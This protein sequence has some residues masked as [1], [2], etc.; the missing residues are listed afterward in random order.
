M[1]NELKKLM[2]KIEKFENKCLNDI[3]KA[4]SVAVYKCIIKVSKL[5]P[6]RVISFRCGNGATFIEISGM[7]KHS[8]IILEDYLDSYCDWSASDLIR[9]KSHPLLEL[10]KVAN[11][12]TSDGHAL[13]RP[14]ITA[15]NGELIN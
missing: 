11:T 5:Y 1:S 7:L 8:S 15:K 6:K 13:Y 4:Y 12:V 3:E 9:Y 10:S 14:R 2:S